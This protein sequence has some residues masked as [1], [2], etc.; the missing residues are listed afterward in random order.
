M[1]KILKKGANI[2]LTQIV[3][4][5]DEILIVIEWCKKQH[6]ETE[7]DIDASAFMLGENHKISGDEDFIFYNQ[8]KSLDG[9]FE[10]L[11]ATEPDTQNFKVLLNRIDSNPIRCAE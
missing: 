8:P 7:L 3:P 9:S 10:L 1:T 6:D 5:N 2:S 4:T 11:T